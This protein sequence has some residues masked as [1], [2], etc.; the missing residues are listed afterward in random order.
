M[1]YIHFTNN[2]NKPKISGTLLEHCISDKI[3]NSQ[4]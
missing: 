4:L 1:I 2:N 3:P